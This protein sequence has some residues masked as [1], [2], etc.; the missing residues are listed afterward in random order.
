MTAHQKLVAERQAELNP[1]PVIPSLAGY[2]V[3]LI[4]RARA[5]RVILKYEWLGT[6]GHS[7]E[8][9]GLISPKRRI[10]GVACFGHGPQGGAPSALGTPAMCLERGA[11]VHYAPRNAASFLINNACK[12]ISR[13][14]DVHRFFA[15]GDPHAGEYGGVYQAAGWRY[16]G[17][18]LD[19]RQ[20]RKR[21]YA[22]LRPGGDPGDPAQWQ[23]T[24]ELRRPGKHMT[25]EE[26]REKGWTIASREAKHVYGTVVGRSRKKWLKD[27]PERPYPAPQPELKRRAKSKRPRL[28]APA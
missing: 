6:M 5:E 17:Q 14:R 7:I 25:F 26:A 18:G 13:L 9:V 8:F 28:P 21:R 15:Y 10:H 22:V 12:L 16:L 23:S 20:G 3:E 24:R 4:S 11:C 1:K 2:T 19:G 27:T